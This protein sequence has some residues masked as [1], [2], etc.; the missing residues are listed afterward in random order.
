MEYSTNSNFPRVVDPLVYIQDISIRNKEVKDTFDEKIAASE[1]NYTEAQ[2]FATDSDLTNI[3]AD[4][5]NMIQHRNDALIRHVR[6]HDP[7]LGGDWIRM[8]K[9]YQESVNPG[10]YTT[11]WVS[12]KM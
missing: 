1:G 9:Y 3:N 5:A 11:V 6:T 2:Q 12:G 10:M 7:Y 4:F 8:N